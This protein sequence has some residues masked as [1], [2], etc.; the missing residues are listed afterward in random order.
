MKRIFLLGGYDLEMITIRD[1]L[2]KYEETYF[3]NKLCWDNA[4]LSSY[5]DVLDQYGNKTDTVIYGIELQPSSS[6]TMYANYRLIDHHNE[7]MRKPSALI[8]VAEILNHPLTRYEQLIAANDSSYI[9][10]MIKLGAT[11]EEVKAIRRKDR[12]NQG[13]TEEDEELAE[14]ALKDKIE[15]IDDL[16]IIQSKTARFSAIT[17]RL[18]PYRKLL[19]YTD[20]EWVYYGEDT[21]RII[22]LFQDK[23]LFYGGGFAGFVGVPQNKYSQ[24]EIEQMK[25]QI[26]KTNINS[27]K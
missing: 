17:D 12:I 3:D 20:K 24:E 25:N 19:I 26:I 21:D 22:R 11:H 18:Y 23:T 27:K 2:Q 13:V 8:Q 9:S 6:V 14:Q 5:K 15:Q 10:G 16:I 7:Y 1:L 4:L